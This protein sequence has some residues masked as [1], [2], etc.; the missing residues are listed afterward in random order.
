MGHK[1][2]SPQ[3]AGKRSCMGTWRKTNQ[4]KTGSVQE[5][6]NSNTQENYEI[7]NIIRHKRH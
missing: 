6:L 1:R 4:T 3:K 2:H 5:V 7:P